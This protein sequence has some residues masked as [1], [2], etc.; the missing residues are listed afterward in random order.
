METDRK[1]DNFPRDLPTEDKERGSQAGGGDR[2]RQTRFG[3][4]W[5][6]AEETKEVKDAS[7][8]AR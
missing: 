6:K 3:S 8:Q 2:L 4:R 7:F 1:D 5:A